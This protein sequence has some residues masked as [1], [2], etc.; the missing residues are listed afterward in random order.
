MSSPPLL[1]SPS[2]T[3][4]P[5]PPLTMDLNGDSEDEEPQP[6][7]LSSP[8]VV[9]SL[10]SDSDDDDDDLTLPT[11]PAPAEGDV[12][13]TMRVAENG[14]DATRTAGSSYLSSLSSRHALYAP[15]SSF[16]ASYSL[17]T[18]ATIPHATS[19]HSLAVPPCCSH[20]YT[21]GADGFIRRYALHPMLNNNASEGVGFNNLTM[22]S[23]SNAASRGEGEKGEGKEVQVG[24]PVLVGYWENDEMGP[25]VDELGKVEGGGKWGAKSPTMA[26]VGQSP[27]YSLAVQRDE[28]WGLSGTAVS[29]YSFSFGPGYC[30]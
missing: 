14:D 20:I 29:E 27:V 9:S 30:N 12:T 1:P 13:G 6:V 3:C 21:G 25:W 8:S 19:I 23:S 16:P 18:I 26:A 10:G 17:Q 4:T 15:P 11:A 2:P 7:Q 22:K 24:P 28:L 5:H